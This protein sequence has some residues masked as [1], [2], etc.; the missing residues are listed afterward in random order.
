MGKF[1]EEWILDLINYLNSSDND[2]QTCVNSNHNWTESLAIRII[3]IIDEPIIKERCQELFNKKFLNNDR[4][5]LEIELKN[6]V[7]KIKRLDNEEN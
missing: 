4:E 1:A 5:K 2:R 6:I 7:A 3:A